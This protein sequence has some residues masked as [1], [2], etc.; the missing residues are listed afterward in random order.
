MKQFKDRVFI[1]TGASSGMGRSTALLFAKEGANLIL[2]GRNEKNGN[3]LLRELKALGNESYFHYGD[4]GFE[5]TNR[6][7][8]RIA[9][10]S[11]GKLDGIICHAGMLGLGAVTEI[12]QEIWTK[13]FQV[14]VDAV[15]NLS[16]FAIPEFLRMGK[17]VILINSSIAAFK[18]FPNHPAYCAS[19]A[20]VQSLGR[21]LA[22]EYGPEIRVAII[23]PGP[24]DTP[25]I[26]RSTV[27]FDN[28]ADIV[29][30]TRLSLPMKRLGTP[31]DIAELTL[32]LCSDRA[33]W[34]TGASIT[35]DGGKTVQ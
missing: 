8:V 21:Q 22:L 26:R 31:D 14:N 18:A 7:L 3:K 16:R 1:I 17:G 34:I 15:F 4:I 29:E 12:S 32:F 30:S 20:A 10:A 9:V 13:T 35:V 6:E 23:C 2:S 27:A 11:Y 19:K 28:P 5:Q 25:M 24:V 33:S